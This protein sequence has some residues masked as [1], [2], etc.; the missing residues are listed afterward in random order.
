MILVISHTPPSID[1][2]KNI[3]DLFNMKA[4]K[5]KVYNGQVAMDNTS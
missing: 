2:N 4:S 1:T 3:R 5:K